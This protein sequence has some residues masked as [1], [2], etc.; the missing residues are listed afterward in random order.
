MTLDGE[1]G[2]GRS[3]KYLQMTDGEGCQSKC[4]TTF[5]RYL[6]TERVR[7]KAQPTL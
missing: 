7:Q 2:L 5:N 3:L 1:E 6:S 4:R